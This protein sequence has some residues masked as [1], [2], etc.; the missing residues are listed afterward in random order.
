[1]FGKRVSRATHIGTAPGT[2][3]GRAAATLDGTNLVHSLNAMKGREQ[4]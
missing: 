4:A 1:M 2:S 3:T